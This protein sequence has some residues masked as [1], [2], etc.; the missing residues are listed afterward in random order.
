MDPPLVSII[1]P[2]W[3]RGDLLFDRCIP[4]VQAQDY[5]LVEHV[6]VSDGP[7]PDLAARFRDHRTAGQSHPVWY[8]ELP[9]HE[10]GGHWGTYARLLGIEMASGDLIGYVDDDDALRPEHCSKLAAALAAHPEAA[11]AYSHMASHRPP[12][13]EV[14]EIGW[15]PPSCGSIGTPMI[16][17]RRSALEHGTWGQPSD[18]EDW[19]LCNRWVHA[20]LE[21][22]KVEEITVDV[23]PSLYYGR[24]S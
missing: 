20:G 21:Y 9:R 13:G 23:W 1:T 16:V 19:D 17:H 15:D 8:Y 22:V 18:F 4:G 3:H 6:I 7:D 11:W 10:P 14:T 24:V 12:L 2:T 5:P